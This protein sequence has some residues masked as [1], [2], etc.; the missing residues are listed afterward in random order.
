[1]GRLYRRTKDGYFYG[2]YVTPEGKRVQRSLKT[3]DRAV[4]KERL[5]L[6]ELAATP[7][8]RGRK[9]RLSDAIDH[10]I[11]MLRHEKAAGTVS[12]TLT[13]YLRQILGFLGMDNV[14]FIAA[15]G[16]AMGEA[17]VLEGLAQARERIDALGLHAPVDGLQAA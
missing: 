12:D 17:S 16:M 3:T 8:A 1:M 13:P 15:E 9:Q 6:A 14:T 11:T 4:A 7:Q 5:R 2:D 10:M